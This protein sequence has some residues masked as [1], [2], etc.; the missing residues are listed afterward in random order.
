MIVSL[1][2][3]LGDKASTNLGAIH[4]PEQQEIADSFHA[5]MRS[6][7]SVP[8]TGD[9]TTDHVF[10]AVCFYAQLAGGAS[11][12]EAGEDCSEQYLD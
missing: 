9:S 8:R 10:Y 5:Q 4:T 12:A 7:R 6:V 2:S 1:S 11:I 3:F